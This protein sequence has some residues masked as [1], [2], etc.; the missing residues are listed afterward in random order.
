MKNFVSKLKKS[1]VAVASVAVASAVAVPAAFADGTATAGSDDGV[2]STLTTY[3]ST[4]TGDM[5]S[6]ALV[7]IGI[8]AIFIAW[9][10]GKKLF[11]KVAS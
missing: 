10:F 11:K 9:H 6:I 7:A 5:K 2:V 3:A 8:F 1:A 4:V